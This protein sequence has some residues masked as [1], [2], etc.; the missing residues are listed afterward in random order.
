[1][2]RAIKDIFRREHTREAIAHLL[3]LEGNGF[4][5]MLMRTRLRVTVAARPSSSPARFFFFCCRSGAARQVC[6]PSHAPTWIEL[7]ALE[8]HGELS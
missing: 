2:A 6:S 7:V 1:M 8:A 4:F 3:P 5:T